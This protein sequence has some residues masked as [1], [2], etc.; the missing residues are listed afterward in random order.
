M[1][2]RAV[3]RRVRVEDAARDVRF[4]REENILKLLVLI[5][6]QPGHTPCLDGLMARQ[7]ALIR[8][9]VIAEHLL[10]QTDERPEL[11]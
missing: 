4:E 3:A 5:E 9:R 11:A 2:R 8:H 7:L 6:L 1:P 10:V